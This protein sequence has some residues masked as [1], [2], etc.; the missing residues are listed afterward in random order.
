ME[1]CLRALATWSGAI[2]GLL[3][4]VAGGLIPAS[5]P[6]VD[7]QGWGLR[8][9][10]I[11]LQV[12]ALL[13]TALVTGPRSALL[14]AVAYLSVG[15]FQLPVFQEGGGLGYLLDPGF[16][17][18]AGFVPAAWITGRLAR[19]QG[20][21]D[22]LALTAAAALGLMVLQFCGL[23]NL[24]LGAAA[25]RWDTA[26]MPMLVGYG[27]ALIPQLLLCC[28]AGLVAWILRRILLVQR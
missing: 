12:P 16:G 21:D 2:V 8:P 27:L 17:Y 5:V 11:T 10:G 26:L 23:M 15:L 14:A 3:L 19:Q 28:A 18:L 6:W 4:I 13:L 7:P 1:P 20:M 24:L 9:L 22:P 25:G